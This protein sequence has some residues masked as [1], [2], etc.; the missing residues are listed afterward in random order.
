MWI[1]F[2]SQKKKKIIMKIKDLR[3]D[4]LIFRF[5]SPKRIWDLLIYL[6]NYELHY[7]IQR[8]SFSFVFPKFFFFSISYY[9]NII[10][11]ESFIKKGK[12]R[13]I[14]SITNYEIK[15]KFFFPLCFSFVF[16]VSLPFALIRMRLVRDRSKHPK[17][18]LIPSSIVLLNNWI[19]R[20]WSPIP[21]QKKVDLDWSETQNF[22]F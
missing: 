19:F 8:R 11:L 22:K 1:L 20:H 9:L 16:F 13:K 10:T 2:M 12:K 21:A 18:V 6:W 14:H 15:K 4:I 7:L 17:S 5:F 3:N